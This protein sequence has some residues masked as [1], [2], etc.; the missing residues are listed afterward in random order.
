MINQFTS[1]C[2]CKTNG[3]RVRSSVNDNIVVLS[4]LCFD[5]FVNDFI[6]KRETNE[7]RKRN[8]VIEQNIIKL[9]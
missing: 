2:T 1:W 6:F 8:R 9:Q 4:V 7:T 3:V 5:L